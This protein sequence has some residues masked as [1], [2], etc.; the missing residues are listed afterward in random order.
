M[1]RAASNPLVGCQLNIP[2][3]GNDV[4]VY[5]LQTWEFVPG[6]KTKW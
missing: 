6:K 5:G 2:D 3:L 1:K 4:N